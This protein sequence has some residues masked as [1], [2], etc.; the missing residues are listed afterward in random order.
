MQNPEEQ[1][2][3]YE[4]FTMTRGDTTA[5]VSMYE[6]GAALGLEKIAAKPS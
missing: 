6:T 5:Q 3:L 4:L 2:Y 1:A